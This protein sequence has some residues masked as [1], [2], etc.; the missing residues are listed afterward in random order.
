MKYGAFIILILFLFSCNQNKKIPR[1]VLSQMKMKEVM[2]DM[3]KADEFVKQFVGKD[4]SKDQQ[5]ESE[6]LYLKIFNALCLQFVKFQNK[7]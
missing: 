7:L 6:K 3:M 1:G 4:S 5:L 2:W